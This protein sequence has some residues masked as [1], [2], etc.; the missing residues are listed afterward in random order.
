MYFYL[1]MYLPES[2]FSKKLLACIVWKFTCQGKQAS[3]YVTS[4]KWRNEGMGVYIALNNFDHITTISS[5]IVP[6]GLLVAEGP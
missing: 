1:A 4:C 6:R 5:Q 3:T 2:L